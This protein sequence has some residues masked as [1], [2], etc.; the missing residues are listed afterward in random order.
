MDIS[1]PTDIFLDGQAT[2]PRSSNAIVRLQKRHS[3]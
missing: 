2:L 3:S 1:D